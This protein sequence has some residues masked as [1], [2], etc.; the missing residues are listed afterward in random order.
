MLF[1]EVFILI[2]LLG[3]VSVSVVDKWFTGAL[4]WQNCKILQMRVD[5]IGLTK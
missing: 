1:S 3:A 4:M 5:S 2:G